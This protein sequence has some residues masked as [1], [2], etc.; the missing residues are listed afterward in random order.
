M[1]NKFSS[2][3][4]QEG[5]ASSR[6]ASTASSK[7]ESKGD[8]KSAQQQ[9]TSDGSPTEFRRI[10][11]N[12]KSFSDLENGLIKCGLESSN[13]LVFFDFTKSN[14]TKGQFSCKGRSLHYE[15]TVVSAPGG[16]APGGPSAVPVSVRG[17][18]LVGLNPYEHSFSLAARTLARFDDDGIIPAWLFGCSIT[19]DKA[20]RALDPSGNVECKRLDGVLAAYRE[21]IRGIIPLRKG[22][23]ECEYEPR[24]GFPADIQLMGPT[25]FAPAIYQAIET[26]KAAGNA[27]HIVLIFTDG[28][29]VNVSSTARAIVEASNYPISIVVVGV[30]DGPFSTMET[31]DDELKER[32]FDNLQF[33]DFTKFQGT[34]ASLENPDL[35]FATHVMMEIPDQ[36]KCIKRLKL[37]GGSTGIVA[38]APPA[39]DAAMKGSSTS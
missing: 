13:L 17:R 30:G 14:W 26:V 3:E 9:P 39:Y 36:Y 5:S 28:E 37:L 23:Y 31:F 11:D 38:S 32:R 29:V 2:R 18:S 24:E 33:V 27:Y 20:V 4:Q 19:T 22:S 15:T 8:S 16:V 1:G 12:F 10:A 6:Q 21:R 35:A 34:M 7:P 25:D